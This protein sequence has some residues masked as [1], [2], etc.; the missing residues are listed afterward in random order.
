[1]P[2]S[3]S[4]VGQNQDQESKPAYAYV[5]RFGAS[6]DVVCLTGYDRP[7]TV[8]NLPTWL[9][10]MDPQ[11]FTPGPIQHGDVEGEATFEKRTC[12]VML[13]SNDERLRRFFLTATAEKINIAIIRVNG[14]AVVAGE[15]LDYTTDGFIKASGVIGMV[16][17]DRDV[18][19]CTITPE[20]Y[21]S[22]RGVPRFY[23][24]RSCNYVLGGPGCRVDLED[25][26]LESVIAA[27]DPTNRILILADSSPG[28]AQYFRSGYLIHQTTGQKLGIAWSDEEAGT[29][30]V[31]LKMHFWSPDLAPG[32]G[33]KVYPGCRHTPADCKDKF[34]NEANFGG[35]SH[36][37][38]RNPVIHGVR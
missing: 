26:A 27:T 36:I 23:F 31:I 28:D 34:D 24:S 1:M 12:Q 32:N 4:Q 9:G 25:F 10:T 38:N 3:V 8:K 33:V 2:L 7:L 6:G 20:P 11:T 5:L 22:N 13:G 15:E 16:G 21:L 18:I 14:P 17:F 37:P 19:A 30:R 35:F 29:E